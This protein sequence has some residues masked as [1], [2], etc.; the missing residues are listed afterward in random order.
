[1][2]RNWLTDVIIALQHA[3]AAPRIIATTVTAA[4]GCVTPSCVREASVPPD[5]SAYRLMEPSDSDASTGSPG[6]TECRP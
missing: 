1:M 5:Q 4:F 3:V 6:Q 2:F